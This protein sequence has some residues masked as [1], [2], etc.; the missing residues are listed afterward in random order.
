MS[1]GAAVLEVREVTK[2]FSG[3]LAVDGVSLRLRE[4]ER[5]ALIGPN[6][7][8]KTTLFNLI[9]R[10]LRIDSGEIRY[11]DRPIHNLPPDAICRLGLTRTFQITSI[12]PQLSVRENIQVALF[13][14]TGSARNLLRAATR[15]CRAEAEAVLAD[16]GLDAIAGR[17]SGLLSYGDQKRLELAMALA[18]EPKVLLLDE[19][20]AGM[21][22][23]TRR[24]MV[25]LVRRIC[26]DRGLTLLFCEHDMD[27]VF[28][29]A[30]SITVL[31]QGRVLTEGAPEDVRRDP[32]V[33][34]IYLGSRHGAEPAPGPA[35]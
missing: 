22:A 31:H 33:R 18:L 27:A 1:A 17:E 14:R 30:D 25:A 20:T 29:I 3:A 21:E 4:G 12:Y 2:R 35:S 28:S 32:Q 9:S 11:L 24:E 26:S 7:A 10:R 13:A 15:H 6:G 34:S 16:V 23:G 19:P 5:R 8:G